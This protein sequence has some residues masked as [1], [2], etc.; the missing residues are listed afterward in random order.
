MKLT[1]KIVAVTGGAGA[2]GGAI[3]HGLAA[4]GAT[5]ILLDLASPALQQRAHELGARAMA[6][7]VRNEASVQTA[8]DNLARE[9]QHLDAI[10][11][12]AGVQLHGLDGPAGDVGLDVWQKTL[13]INLT[14]AFLSAKHALPLLVEAQQ[15]SLILIGSPTALTMSGAGF[16]AYA[17]SKAGMMA[18]GRVIA[19]DY[20]HRGVR[21]NVVVPGTM[22]TPLIEEL[23][24]A[25]DVHDAL[26]AGTPIG[27]IG[28]PEDLVGITTWLVSDDSS[29]ATGGVFPVD[30]GLT[31]R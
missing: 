19:A 3:A 5:V 10:V 6:T 23:L 29:S 21:A 27:R 15:S 1:G 24:A 31:A 12:C 8:F 16:T 7:D 26:L 2:L 14:G 11:I 25:P 13:D 9:F 17:A 28:R 18:L 20:A 4:Q 22:D 30:G